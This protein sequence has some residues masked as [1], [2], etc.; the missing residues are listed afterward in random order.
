MTDKELRRLRRQDLLQ[1]LVE[2]SRE[3]ARLQ[4]ETDEKNEEIA[5]LNESLERL[6]GKLDEKDAQ[7]ERLKERLN[8]KDALLEKLKQ[9]LNEKDALLEKLKSRLDEKDT[10][11]GELERRLELA[12]RALQVK[13]RVL[14]A[15]L[16][17]GLYP[18]TWRYLGT[19]KNHRSGICLSGGE[20]LGQTRKETLEDWAREYLG[21]RM[22][23]EACPEIWMEN[24]EP[25]RV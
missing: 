13:R 23:Q 9:R 5:Q 25:E 2:Q 17:G 14:E 3:A 21:G 8:E 20:G 24:S 6:K 4:T 10:A 22:A 18:Y 11:I 7:L 16:K 12:A 15:F 1:L 19:L